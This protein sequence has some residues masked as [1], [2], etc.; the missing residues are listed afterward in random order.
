MREIIITTESGTDLPQERAEAL[1]IRVIPMHV[2]T[3]ALSR[4]D[5][6]FPVSEVFEYYR[7]T[8]QIPTTSAVNP[9]E[10]IDFFTRLRSEHPEAD[11]LHIA[12]TSK[13]SS[14]YQNTAIALEE[15]SNSFSEHRIFLADSKNVSGGISLICEKAAE[16]AKTSKDGQ[17]AKDRLE[18]WINRA[19]VSF[20]PDTLEYLKAGGR[21]SNAAYL[22]ASI[23][24]LKPLINIEDGRL[25]ASK[26]YRGTMEHVAFSYLEEFVERNHLDRDLFYLFYTEG[27]PM[28]LFERLMQAASRMGFRTILKTRVGCVISCHGGPGALGLAGF[29][30]EKEE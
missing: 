22:G 28:E 27:F 2:V 11:I 16:L 23:L 8:R 30:K 9:Q 25:I 4:P 5:G 1:K 6:S 13:A 3:G 24:K 12:Y 7:K 18:S 14:T 21:V 20:L 26:K 29:A 10:Y 15:L 19:R 17:E